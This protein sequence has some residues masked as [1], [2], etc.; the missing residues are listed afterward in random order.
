[1]GVCPVYQARSERKQPQQIFNGSSV[2]RL[3][4]YLHLAHHCLVLVTD[5]QTMFGYDYDV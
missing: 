5:R 4:A 2:F 3:I 1:M